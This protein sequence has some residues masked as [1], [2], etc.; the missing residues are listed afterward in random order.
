[1]V[2]LGDR[3]K[4]SITGATGIAVARCEWLHGCIRVSVQPEELKDGK[5]QD[6]Y[7]VDEPQLEVLDASAVPNVPFWRESAAA[8][9]RRAAGPRPEVSRA[10]DPTR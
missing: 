10:P 3:V 4:D 5:P 9:P 6:L 8:Q 1:M 7:T 2:G